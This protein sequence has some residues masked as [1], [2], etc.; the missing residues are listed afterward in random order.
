M[1]ILAI[2][3]SKAVHAFLKTIFRD[4]DHDLKE[5]MDG[6]QAMDMIQSGSVKPDVILLDWEMP[7][8]DGMETL[9]AIRDGKM[10][11][12]VIM[13]T[14]RNEVNQIV[15]ALEKGANEYI[16]KP[17]TKDILFEKLSMVMGTE[18]G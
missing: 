17:F 9:A 8:M 2:D 6:K 16:M 13:V 12:P 18:I 3:D 7:V 5:A 15:V 11:V 4:T 10:E 14:S 1:N